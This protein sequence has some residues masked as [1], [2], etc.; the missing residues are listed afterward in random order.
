MIAEVEINIA[1]LQDNSFT[2]CK[3]ELKFF[4]AAICGTLTLASPT[5]SFRNSIAH[6]KTGFL[7]PS[8]AWDLALEEAVAVVEDKSR[9]SAIARTAFDFVQKAYGWDRHAHTIARA[10]FG[11]EE[12]A[13]A[14]A[15]K[16]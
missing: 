2:N 1:P 3:S 13:S 11:A 5:V 4:E 8:H 9:Y 6:G 16:G 7:V 12:P 15:R 14:Q 10:V